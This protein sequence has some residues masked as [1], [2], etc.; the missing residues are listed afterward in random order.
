MTKTP[1]SIITGYLGAGKTTLLKRIIEKLDRKFAIIMN[2]FGEIGIDTQIIQGKNINIAELAGGCVCCSLSG[3]FEEAIRE[4]I[5]SYH[6]EIIIVETTGVAEPDALVVDISDT[7]PNVKLDS[8]ITVTDADALARFPNIGRT[9]KVQIEMGDII[10]LNKID[11]VNE[12]QRVE[13]K[14]TLRTINKKAP[15]IETTHCNVDIDLL[16]GLE[17]EHHITKTHHG[18]PIKFESFSY[19]LT[20]PIPQELFEQ[21]LQQLPPSVYRL[22]GF[23]EF[24]EDSSYL[25]NYVAGRWDLEPANAENH[26]LVF[27]GENIALI[28]NKIINQMQR[29]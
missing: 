21:F 8:V 27:I 22:K 6:P 9:G 19:P 12:T 2:E 16:F 1:I 13:I 5:E 14:T 7:H 26:V 25:I 10:L 24:E 20:K 28:K 17:I 23:V 15:M 11:L 29:W 18:H 3:E 4:V